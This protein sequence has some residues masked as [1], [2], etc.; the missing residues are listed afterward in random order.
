MVAGDRVAPVRAYRDLMAERSRLLADRSDLAPADIDH[1][2]ALVSDWTLLADLALA[3]LV[4]WV[5]T[6]NKTGFIAV[7]QV[8]PTTGP[9][10]LPDD[11]VG[12]FIAHG[13][14]AHLDRAA[15]RARVDTAT[16]G[17][18]PRERAIPVVR[19]GSVIAVI[20]LRSTSR[21]SSA[22]SLEAVY[23]QCSD[24][25]AGMIVSG[26]FPDREVADTL[27]AP[28][29]AGDGLIRLDVAGRVEFASPNASSAFHRLGLA[30]GL[31]G[32]DLASLALRLSRQPGPVDELL[33][34]IAGG[35]RSGQTVIEN[36][37]AII[38][39]RTLVVMRSDQRVGA[40]VLLR[41]VTDLR[42][43]QRALVS[44]EATIREIHHRVK[45]NLATVVALLRM[46]SRRTDGPQAAAALQ[47]AARRV[48]VIA[49]VHEAL[50]H[51]G[52]SWVAFDDIV[53]RIGDMFST[54]ADGLVIER[55]GL[56]GAVPPEVATP[57]ATVLTE[58]TANAITHG[59]GE[60]P[61]SITIG[62]ERIGTRLRMQV[63]DSGFGLP[64]GFDPLHSAG[65]GLQIVRTLVGE[66]LR[67]AVAWEPGRPT[68]TVA[69]VDLLIPVTDAETRI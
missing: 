60:R 68:G 28:P 16:A 11:V 32:A 62:F 13:R 67:G 41:D 43:Q 65:L 2:R 23:R 31:V 3:D 39:L 46:Q 56:A 30:A 45:N 10:Q 12:T 38:S 49:V 26:Q 27:E 48:G 42:R 59:L 4:L 57:L 18:A 44:K 5:P 9:T 53:D 6:W 24:D 21:R 55:S 35:R 15:A 20:S 51:S 69:V 29:R 8:R 37:E 40:I 25:L 64:A 52:G 17:V 7:A 1:L 58:L 63:S 34:Q 33:T 54:L 19:G 22:G 14:R 36:N 61:G 50:A 66:E 47:E